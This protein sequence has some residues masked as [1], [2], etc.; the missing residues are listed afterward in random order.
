MP[1]GRAGPLPYLLLAFAPLTWAGNVIVGRALA[2]AVDPVTINVVRWGGAAVLLA[3]FCGRGL[4]THRAELARH[5][6]IVAGLGVSGMALFHLLQYTALQYTTALNVSLITAMTPLYIVLLAW[7]ISGDRLDSRRSAGVT[8]SIVGA[9]VIVAKG[10]LANLIRLDVQLG[11]VIQ[12]GALMFWALYCVLLRYRPATIPPLPF[13]LATI[14]P[15]LALSLL[16]YGFV[17]PRLD[18]STDVVM[19]L[20]YLAVFPSTLAYI[21]WGAGVTV[22]GPHMAGVFTNLLPVY[23]ALLAV[24]VLGEPFQLYHLLAAALVGL[25]IW[26]ASRPLRAPVNLQARS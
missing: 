21:A 5:W 23:G 17:S 24:T 14:G 3:L 4:W 26:V 22:L 2:D 12:I 13:L 1:T 11:D 9:L 16:A 7:V 6:R 25:G 8:L 18:A 10:D 20:L 15:G 19:G